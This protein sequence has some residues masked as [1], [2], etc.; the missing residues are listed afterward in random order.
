MEKRRNF[1]KKLLT[2]TA[3]LY[4]MS[5]KYAFAQIM[6]TKV[7][8]FKVD[9]PYEGIDWKKIM[10]VPS[11]SHV[12]IESQEKLD[13]I[14]NDFKLRHIPISNYY[15]SAPYYPAEKVKYNQFLVQNF[16]QLYNSD[17]SKPGNEKWENGKLIPGP[18]DWNKIIMDADKGWYN[19]LPQNV[20]ERLP[21]KTGDY[22]YKKI[23]QDVIISPNAEHHG[24]TNAPLHACAPGSLYSSGNFDV[25]DVFKT[26]EHGYA[27]GTGLKWQVAFQKMLDNLLFKDAG[28]VTI[29][30]PTWSGLHYDQVIE[31]LDFDKRVLGIEIYNDTCATNYGEPELGWALKLW[32]E[33][34]STNR[35]CLGFCV[36]DHTIGRGKNILLVPSFTEYD[37]LKAYRTGSF[38]GALTGETIKFTNIMLEKDRLKIGLNSPGT[39]RF[40]TNNGEA[41]KSVATETTF[42]IPSNSNGTPAISYVRVEAIHENGEQIFS[43]P[44]RFLG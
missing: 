7:P 6:G 28:G 12:H 23:P 19:E 13:K 40:V 21:I 10:Y 9:N 41:Q 16:E 34:L 20:K 27:P 5:N 1:I 37:C 29:N 11:A 43:Q 3:V 44:I 22:I 36:P 2:S 26:I 17:N 39:I 38:F 25:H 18:I 35:R 8:V 4:G 31:M 15:P 33:I 42:Q 14:Y 30:H 32:D 24:F